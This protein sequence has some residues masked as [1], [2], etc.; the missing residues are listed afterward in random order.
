MRSQAAHVPIDDLQS[1]H[2]KSRGADPDLV[3]M[4]AAI[5]HISGLGNTTRIRDWRAVMKLIAASTR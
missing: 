5:K 4:T 2:R 3:D 1:V